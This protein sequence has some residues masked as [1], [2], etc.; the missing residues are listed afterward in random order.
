MSDSLLN[1]IN[2]LG[3]DCFRID[4]HK[5][6]YIDPFQIQP[7]VKA[8]IL[9]ITHEHFD[10]CSLDDIEKIVSDDTVIITEKN[11]AEKLSG[12][13]QVLKPGEST[14]VDGIRIETVP[15]YNLNKDFH[16]KE[17]G[18]LGFIVEIDGE[19]IY[20][21]GDADYI[22]EM[23]S[24]KADIALLPVSGTYVMTAEEAVKA[25]LVLKPKVAIPMHYGAI[26]GSLEDAQ[27]F[28]EALE[29]Q[30]T[31]KIMDKV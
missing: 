26:V 29:G 11:S 28:K 1:K 13:I 17:N 19:R 23:E 14:L 16:P 25:A 12:N 22:P 6:I 27:R 4:S 24:I 15:S 2:W 31:V 9:L 3:H 7:G 10:H 5:V 20:H 18:W 8:D 30:V 21:T